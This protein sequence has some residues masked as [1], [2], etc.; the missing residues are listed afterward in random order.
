MRWR[1]V[2]SDYFWLQYEMKG[3]KNHE[4]VRINVC[5]LQIFYAEFNGVAEELILTWISNDYLHIQCGGCITMLIQITEL[6]RI[7]AFDQ[8]QREPHK[9]LLNRKQ[10]QKNWNQSRYKQKKKRKMYHQRLRIHFFDSH[11]IVSKQAFFFSNILFRLNVF[12]W[13]EIQCV[14]AMVRIV[15]M[16]IAVIADNSTD[17]LDFC[18]TNDDA[19]K[20]HII[21]ENQKKIAE[22]ISNNRI[23]WIKTNGV[24]QI[25]IKVNANEW[26]MRMDMLAG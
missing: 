1:R 14:D 22:K 25:K 10:K 7:Y 6:N 20:K 9:N 26:I 18:I 2:D 24:W 8:L 12:I 17:D 16:M 5:G 4:Y 13:N 15:M 21:D 19:G 11:R 3:N 23:H